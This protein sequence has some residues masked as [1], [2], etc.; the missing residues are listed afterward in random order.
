MRGRVEYPGEVGT[1]A[2]RLALPTFTYFPSSRVISTEMRA[3]INAK[4]RRLIYFSS[5]Q[6][7]SRGSASITGREPTPSFTRLFFSWA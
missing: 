6:V 7:I 3:A 4:P 1:D 5:S 2:W